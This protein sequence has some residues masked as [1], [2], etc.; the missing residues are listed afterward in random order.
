MK[1]GTAL[2]GD[3]TPKK[4][5]KKINRRERERETKLLLLFKKRK[6]RKR[7]TSRWR[8]KFKRIGQTERERE[9]KQCRNHTLREETSKSFF[10]FSF[11]V[12]L[13]SNPR[14]LS[15]SIKSS[16]HNKAL[17]LSLS[18]ALL[19]QKNLTPFFLFW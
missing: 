11:F 9:R 8:L 12:F 7:R 16:L 10:S 15:Q 3:L 17:S 5:I 6:T 4:K 18:D 2:L 19:S 14:N 13:S 1:A